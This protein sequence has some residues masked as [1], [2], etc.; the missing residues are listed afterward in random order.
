VSKI[1]GFH[2][3]EEKNWVVELSCGHQ[4]HVWQAA[5]HKAPVGS[6]PRRARQ[7]AGA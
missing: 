1:I 5:V 3:N 2:Q 4:Q 7:Q 6:H